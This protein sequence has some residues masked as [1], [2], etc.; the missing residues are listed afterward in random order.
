MLP[1]KKAAQ[2][3]QG[4]LWSALTRGAPLDTERPLYAET[5]LTRYDYGWSELNG[6]RTG[7][8]KYIDA[9]RPELYDLRED[10]H[11]QQDLTA[12]RPA[13]TARL[14]SEHDALL[15][16]AT[17]S[18]VR[19]R[20]D[21]RLRGVA[22]GELPDLAHAQVGRGAFLPARLEPALEGLAQIVGVGGQ[23]ALH[24]RVILSR[25]HPTPSARRSG[26]NPAGTAAALW[27]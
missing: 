10:P 3:T 21:E 25:R 19:D 11:E 24:V 6:V 9:P 27:H 18:A 22:G 15:E 1:Y 13:E 4:R 23:G 26:A 7:Q 8:L 5:Y 17:V 2:I 14:R 16:F 20:N 12:E